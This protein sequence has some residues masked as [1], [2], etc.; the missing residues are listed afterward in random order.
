MGVSAVGGAIRV[1]PLSLDLGWRFDSTALYHLAQIP[2]LVLLYLGA[3]ATS[4]TLPA[5]ED[6][7]RMRSV[8]RAFSP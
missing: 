5:R 6:G 4:R 7:S 1:L 8:W 3:D 2:G